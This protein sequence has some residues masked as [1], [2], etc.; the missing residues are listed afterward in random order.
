MDW[1][2]CLAITCNAL[3][4]S[5]ESTQHRSGSSSLLLYDLR[6]LKVHIR[7]FHFASMGIP[8]SGKFW[9]IIKERSYCI[10]ECPKGTAGMYVRV[11]DV[12]T[13]IT[14]GRANIKS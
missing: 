3:G 12:S 6:F 5:E 11:A 7:R 14:I 2:S 13:A 1:F 8:P 10:R 4:T 9:L